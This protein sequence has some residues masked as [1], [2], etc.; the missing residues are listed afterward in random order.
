MKYVFK[1]TTQRFEN[2]ELGRPQ[3]FLIK[4]F[5]TNCHIVLSANYPS[6][7]LKKNETDSKS[8]D[9]NNY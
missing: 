4:Y 5:S 8:E 9:I 1:E 3:P 7:R 6:Q 2:H